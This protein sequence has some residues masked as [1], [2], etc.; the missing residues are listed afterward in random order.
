ML[1]IVSVGVVIKTLS[2]IN[3]CGILRSGGDTKFCLVLEGCSVWLIGLPMAILGSVILSL[4]IYATFAM[5]YIEEIV[6]NVVAFKRVST[7]K[8]LRTLV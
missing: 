7:K 8:W 4:P 6:K 2:Y 1:L 5:V 3:I